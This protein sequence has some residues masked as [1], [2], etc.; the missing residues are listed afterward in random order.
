MKKVTEK[1][2]ILVKSMPDGREGKFGIS[3]GWGGKGHKGRK[4]HKSGM[5]E[6]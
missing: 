3:L 1:R 5:A 2:A 4:G 6:N